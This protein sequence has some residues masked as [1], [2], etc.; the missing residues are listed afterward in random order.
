MVIIS[1]CP[2]QS[3]FSHVTQPASNS[4]YLSAVLINV[5]EMVNID[6]HKYV[7]INAYELL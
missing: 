2:Q 5:I 7:Y 1:I 3:A 4:Y 6:E